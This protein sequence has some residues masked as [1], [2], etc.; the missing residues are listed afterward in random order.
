MNPTTNVSSKCKKGGNILLFS[1]LYQFCIVFIHGSLCAIT[2][3]ISIE[4]AFHALSSCCAMNQGC[5]WRTLRSVREHVQMDMFTWVM[6]FPI[7]LDD[8][9]TISSRSKW[10][11]SRPVTKD[12]G[13]PHWCWCLILRQVR[14]LQKAFCRIRLILVVTV[15]KSTQ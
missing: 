2:I 8:A 11:Y 1:L 12:H 15:K 5:I 13:S 6:T 7:M 4:W 9:P 10:L 3:W 14:F